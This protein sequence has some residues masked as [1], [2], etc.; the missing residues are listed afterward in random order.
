M[1]LITNQKFEKMKVYL[2]TKGLWKYY[3][4]SMDELAGEFE[5][6]NITIGHDAKIGSGT[7]IGPDTEICLLYTS[8]SPRD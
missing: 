3:E 4:G 8:P 1:S 5:S 2:K 6:R 7:E